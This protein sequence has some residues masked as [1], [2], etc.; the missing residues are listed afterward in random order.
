M[1]EKRLKCPVLYQTEGLKKGTLPL[2][3][4][5]SFLC[6]FLKCTF[7]SHFSLFFFRFSHFFFSFPSSLILFLSC[8]LWH[9][10]MWLRDSEQ[11]ILNIHC[12]KDFSG[13]TG[14]C[15]QCFTFAL[16]LSAFWIPRMDQTMRSL[17]SR[18][19]PISW[20]TWQLA[21]PLQ[22]TTSWSYKT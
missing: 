19:M 21:L 13:K 15:C 11:H 4:I 16:I 9:Q 8:T 22:S 12:R 1:A 6:D 18:A 10:E 17:S 20:W 3:S 7:Y 5:F 14:K 2:F